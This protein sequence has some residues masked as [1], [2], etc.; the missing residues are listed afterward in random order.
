[1]SF[2]NE[3]TGEVFETN[4]LIIKKGKRKRNFNSFHSCY[5]KAYQKKE[6]S[7]LTMVVERS[8]YYNISKF[9]NTITRK[10]TRKGIKKLGY[11]WTKDIGDER[12]E[13]HFHVLLATSRIE[14]ADFKELFTKKKESYSVQ[15]M[16]T[17]RGMFNYL[18]KK[19]LYTEGK[20]RAYGKSKTFNF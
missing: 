13:K 6:I 16:Q 12:F 11:V 5:I 18:N 19:E 7:I 17:K 8:A 14:N 9:I 4:D 10:L 20:S 15:F 3:D 1:M 2:V